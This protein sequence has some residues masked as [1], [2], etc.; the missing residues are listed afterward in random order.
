MPV[1]RIA[2]FKLDHVI[3]TRARQ[4]H[5]SQAARRQVNMPWQNTLAVFGF[6]DLHSAEVV[7]ALHER[8]GDTGR[9]V[10]GDHNGWAVGRAGLRSEEHTSELQ[11]LMRSSSAVF[12]LKKK[13]PKK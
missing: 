6:V 12:R 1:D 9:H 7:Q 10:L 5:V 3:G 8:A 4:L 13:R 11:S 2:V